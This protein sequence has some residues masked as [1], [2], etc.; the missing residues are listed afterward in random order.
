MTTFPDGPFAQ[1]LAQP[2]ED[3]LEIFV[4]LNDYLRMK[5]R[6]YTVWVLNDFKLFSIK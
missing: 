3:A 5:W 4:E 6:S 1:I 2:G